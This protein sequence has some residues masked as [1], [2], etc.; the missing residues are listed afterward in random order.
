MITATGAAMRRLFGPFLALCAASISQAQPTYSVQP[1]PIRSGFYY[2]KGVIAV[3]PHGSFFITEE[4]DIEKR[5]HYFLHGPTLATTPQDLNESA[6]PN[7]PNTGGQYWNGDFILV[8]DKG[9]TIAQ[10]QLTAN[11]PT[12]NYLYNHMTHQLTDIGLP[13]PGFTPTC[14]NDANYVGGVE[15]TS[16]G[17]L[18]LRRVPDG[19]LKAPT[20][21]GLKD[22]KVLNGPW[23]TD[24]GW[25]TGTITYTDSRGNR[26]QTGY[27]YFESLP[28]GYYGNE[29]AV[30]GINDLQSGADDQVPTYTV[31]G[32]HYNSTYGFWTGFLAPGSDLLPQQSESLH[33]LGL[34]DLG[35]TLG[36][37]EGTL[38]STVNTLMLW[39]GSSTPYTFSSLVTS[40]T[41]ADPVY[42]AKI[43]YN[44]NVYFNV[45]ASGG[46][47]PYIATINLAD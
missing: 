11:G 37:Q 32:Y 10:Q 19:G 17:S 27:I 34:D 46:K 1:I 4:K 39:N 9:I 14:L 20:F 8:N 3:S 6:G 21:T 18:P 24:N 36:Y 35:D 13:G 47:Q 30:L 28:I 33:M 26:A 25:F 16:T 41:Y 5:P 23:L 40:G 42:D 31:V 12:T 45:E 43:D 44:G 7:G 29:T 15:L 22:P 38:D 2:Y